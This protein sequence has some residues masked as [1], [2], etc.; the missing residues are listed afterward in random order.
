MITEQR[1]SSST[2]PTLHWPRASTVTGVQP[3]RSDQECE[4]DWAVQV[5]FKEMDPY[6]GIS[7]CGQLHL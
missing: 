7:V 3:A 4:E 5:S 2:T 6:A 1:G